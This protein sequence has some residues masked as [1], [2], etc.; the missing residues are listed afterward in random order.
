[1][2]AKKECLISLNAYHRLYPG[3]FFGRPLKAEEI[4]DA[5]NSL[6][7]AGFGALAPLATE[8][9]DFFVILRLIDQNVEDFFCMLASGDRKLFACRFADAKK[10]ADSKTL[11]KFGK[12]YTEEKKK[13]R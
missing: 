6:V 12:Y 11:E 4:R 13:L 1:M 10:A 5:G 2:D 3:S 8:K 9:K 7:F